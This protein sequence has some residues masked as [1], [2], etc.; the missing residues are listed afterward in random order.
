VKQQKI[1]DGMGDMH[2]QHFALSTN[3]WSL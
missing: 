2:N 1:I 3:W